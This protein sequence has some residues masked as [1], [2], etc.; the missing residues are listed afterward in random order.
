MIWI[1]IEYPSFNLTEYNFKVSIYQK[2]F[3][4]N[5]KQTYFMKHYHC[6]GDWCGEGATGDVTGR[7]DMACV[8]PQSSDPVWAPIL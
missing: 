5:F 7:H 6:L 3:E 1:F 2:Y 8:Q 4:T